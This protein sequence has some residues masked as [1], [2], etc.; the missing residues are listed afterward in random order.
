MRKIFMITIDC[1]LRTDDVALRQAA[2]EELLNSFA[3]GGA[4]GHIT[5]FVNEND[6]HLTINHPSFLREAIERGDTLGAH[7]HLEPLEGQ[8]ET[9]P[10]LERCGQT[11]QTI[12][13]W[14]DEQGYDLELT[15]HRTGCA[16]QR[17]VIYAVLQNLGYTVV[18]DIVPG[19][20]HHDIRGN[21]A[22]DNTGIP[23]GINPYYHH[24]DDF[25]KYQSQQG[26]LLQFPMMNMVF[27][28]YLSSWEPFNWETVH[29]WEEAFSRKGEEVGVFVWTWHPYEILNEARTEIDAQQVALLAQILSQLHDEDFELMSIGEYVGESGSN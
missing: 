29:A 26:F 24:L 19:R 14:L 21:F 7:D 17:T 20:L 3:R 23:I 13:E 8:Y 27:C 11:K 25:T 12:E 10:L 4:A 1:D 9:E 18:S 16:V 6:F 15:A 22:F 2:L 5:W 28:P